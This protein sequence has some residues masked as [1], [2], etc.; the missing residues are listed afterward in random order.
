LDRAW[1][2][3]AIEAAIVTAAMAAIAVVRMV[4][5]MSGFPSSG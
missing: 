2:G 1:A 3:D 5:V 4:L